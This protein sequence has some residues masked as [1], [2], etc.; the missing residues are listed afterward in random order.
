MFRIPSDLVVFG[1]LQVRARDGCS[2]H[3][4]GGSSAF[5]SDM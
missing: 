4:L 3:G 2:G 5:D 1:P